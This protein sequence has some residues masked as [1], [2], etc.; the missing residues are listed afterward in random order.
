[1]KLVA[2]RRSDFNVIDGLLPHISFTGD[3]ARI[4]WNMT[5][6]QYKY[7][8]PFFP[9]HAVF[10]LPKTTNDVKSKLKILP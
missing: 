3:N 6:K 4:Y 2:T 7:N 10:T 8:K 9:E 5:D 1:M